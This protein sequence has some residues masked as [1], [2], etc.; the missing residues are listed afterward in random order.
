[1]GQRSR[2]QSPATRFLA[3]LCCTI[4]QARLHEENERCLLYLDVSTRKPLIAT[5]EKQLL[6]RHTS[7]ILDKVGK[8]HS[9]ISQLGF[10]LPSCFLCFMLFVSMHPVAAMFSL[11]GQTYITFVVWW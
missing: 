5:A 3:S 7:A 10:A 6:D 8:W 11:C 1:M 4:V 9:C 2:D